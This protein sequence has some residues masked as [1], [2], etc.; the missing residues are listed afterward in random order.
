ML[1]GNNDRLFLSRRIVDGC[2]KM[3]RSVSPVLNAPGMIILEHFWPSCQIL[4]FYS[5]HWSLLLSKLPNHLSFSWLPVVESCRKWA[6][7]PTLQLNQVGSGH[8]VALAF[9]FHSPQPQL[10]EWKTR[11]FYVRRRRWLTSTCR[12]I[13]SITRHVLYLFG[14]RVLA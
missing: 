3:S 8:T 11:P 14:Q 13:T 7:A 4:S 2:N 12:S 9:H 10:C 5:Q 6:T 1:A